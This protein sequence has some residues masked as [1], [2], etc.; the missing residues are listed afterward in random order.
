M[1]EAVKDE[2]RRLR[3]LV[4]WHAELGYNGFDTLDP[5]AATWNAR[6]SLRSICDILDS[7][8]EARSLKAIYEA[9]GMKPR[10][11]GR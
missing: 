6:E 4:Y 8:D 5:K 2:A 7:F 10:F 1:S 9:T 11:W 3:D